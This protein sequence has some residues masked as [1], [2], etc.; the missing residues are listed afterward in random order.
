LKSKIFVA[1]SLF[2]LC[3]TAVYAADKA[4]DKQKMMQDM[5]AKMQAYATP[6]AEQKMMQGMVGSWDSE[7]KMY[8]DPAAP[9]TVSKGTSTYTSIMDGRY[10]RE[11]AEGTFNGMPFHGQGTYGYDN[12]L[13]KYVSTWVDN[14]GTGIM[15]GSGTSTDGGKTINFT[16]KGV[17]IMTGKEANYR[18]VMHKMSDDQY[19]FEMY[20]P[21]MDGKETKMMEITY[22][23][24][25]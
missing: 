23:R 3:I 18:S 13:K 12:M 25:K 24:K 10:I 14:M 17:D 20:G 11:D 16:N 15:T 19:H 7:I 22:N 2:V 6:G 21:G 5:M 1:L 8:E 9:P 4:A